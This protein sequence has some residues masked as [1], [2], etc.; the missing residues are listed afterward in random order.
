MDILF[1]S[2]TEFSLRVLALLGE[3]GRAMTLD[4]IFFVDFIACYPSIFG[5]DG[6]DI[7]GTNTYLLGELP[8]RR[9]KISDATKILLFKNLLNVKLD[10]VK[11]FLYGISNKGV[12]FDLNFDNDYMEKF[13]GN[14]DSVLSKYEGKSEIELMKLLETHLSK[15]KD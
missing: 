6:Y 12:N 2:D 15:E 4:E 3:Y 9:Q 13:R 7:V 1:N 11:G 14:I 8:L 5:I 10:P